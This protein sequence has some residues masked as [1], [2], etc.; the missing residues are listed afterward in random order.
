MNFFYDNFNWTF[1]NWIIEIF[2][3]FFLRFGADH[4]KLVWPRRI[5]RPSEV[6]RFGVDESIFGQNSDP[7]A[8]SKTNNFENSIRFNSIK[9]TYCLIELKRIELNENFQF[10]RQIGSDSFLFFVGLEEKNC[11]R[12]DPTT[13]LRET[14]STSLSLRFQNKKIIFKVISAESLHVKWKRSV[15][16]K[17]IKNKCVNF[18]NL[19]HKFNA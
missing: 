4:V 18:E 16:I 6:R 7:I 3:V 17:I 12:S 11:F 14:L 5:E 1:Y 15:Y 2:S 8:E 13:T 19:T 9:L 10:F